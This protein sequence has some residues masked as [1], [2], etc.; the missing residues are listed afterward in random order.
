MFLY[1]IV[2]FILRPPLEHGSVHPALR[3]HRRVHQGFPQED[4]STA[5]QRLL[6]EIHPEFE[7][8][9]FQ[10]RDTGYFRKVY[11]AFK[12]VCC[13]IYMNYSLSPSRS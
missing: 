4:R 1:Y 3:V 10:G 9:V 13:A 11:R 2:I 7:G 6:G 12:F 5:L 8:V